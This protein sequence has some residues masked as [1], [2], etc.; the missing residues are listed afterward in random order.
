MVSSLG[1]G[2]IGAERVVAEIDRYAQPVEGQTMSLTT[3]VPSKLL[4]VLQVDIGPVG[5]WVMISSPALSAALHNDIEGQ[6]TVS[7]RA[8][9]DIHGAA[10]RRHR[11]GLVARDG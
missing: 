8:V 11:R 2:V 9:I 6:T 1:G 7:V 4:G 3:F 10:P 5:S